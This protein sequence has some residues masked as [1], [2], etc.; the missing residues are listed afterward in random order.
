M[1]AVDGLQQVVDAQVEAGRVPGA[2]GLV[3]EED[4]VT[5]A[6]SGVCS[7]GGEP[8]TPDTIFRYSS[9]TKPILAAAT[10]V[11]VERGRVALDDPVARWLPELAEPMVPRRLDGPLDDVVPA[12]RPITVRAIC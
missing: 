7:I 12:V 6:S 4:D 9:I 8:M 11:L 1:A 3:S 5:V 10:M 2:V